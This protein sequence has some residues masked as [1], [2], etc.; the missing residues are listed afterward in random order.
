MF[1]GLAVKQAPNTGSPDRTG[2]GSPLRCAPGI[3][4]GYDVLRD[5]S[6]AGA[7]FDKLPGL[8]RQGRQGKLCQKCA[9]I[10][11][12]A[13]PGPAPLPPAPL[14]GASGG[15]RGGLRRATLPI[16]FENGE[17]EPAAAAEPIS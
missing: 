9:I 4:Y 16:F 11:G 3:P 2:A 14:R 12:R 10:G 1:Q 5:R 13:P 17:G 15:L 6:R 8:A 7:P